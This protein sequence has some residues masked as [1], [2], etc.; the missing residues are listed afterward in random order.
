TGLV[1]VRF[2][3][4]KS[5]VAFS[6]HVAI[7]PMEG[8]PTLMIRV[9]NERGNHIFD[10]ALSA[11]VTRTTRTAEGVVVYRATDLALV[12]NRAPTLTRS[13]NILHRIDRDSPFFG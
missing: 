1:F 3:L 7:G 8:V 11:V 6:R 4:T 9:G 2:S 10:A 13:W 12:R 5:R